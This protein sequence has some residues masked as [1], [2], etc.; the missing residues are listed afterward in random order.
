MKNFL[1]RTL[2]GAAYV[3]IMVF[4]TVFRPWSLGVLLLLLTVLA[5]NEFLSIQCSNNKRRV[6]KVIVLCG[7]VLLPLAVFVQTYLKG[8]DFFLTLVPYLVFIVFLF[9][10]ELFAEN[11]DPFGNLA[12]TM[13][14]QGYIVL[15]L[16]LM[17]VLAFGSF[18]IIHQEHPFYILP[19]AVLFFVWCNDTGAYLAGSLLGKHKLIPRISPGK[20]WE[21]SIGGAILTILLSVLLWHFWPIMSIFQWMGFAL[22]VVVFGTF[23]DLTESLMKRKLGLKDSG[24]ILPGHGGILD[25]IDSL[26]LAVPSAVIYLYLCGF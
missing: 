9:V 2:T 3:A 12:L 4:C 1:T 13:L 19:L 18:P 17:S 7:S 15:P 16:S 23:G 8:A 22:V 6:N 5:V 21:G 25:R 20:T 10:S 26:L 24:N 11:E 14:S